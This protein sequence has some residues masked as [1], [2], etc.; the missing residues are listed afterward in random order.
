MPVQIYGAQTL[1]DSLEFKYVVNRRT[2]IAHIAHSMS[3]TQEIGIIK[4][5][6]HISSG[7]DEIYASIT[8]TTCGMRWIGNNYFVAYNILPID[9]QLCKS[10][11]KFLPK[12]RLEES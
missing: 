5:G 2:N 3:A 1:Y 12:K 6:K 11:L 4:I 10:C 8:S 9:V 7:K